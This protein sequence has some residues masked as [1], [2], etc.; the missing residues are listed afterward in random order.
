MIHHFPNFVCW[1]E[2]YKIY[3][4]N[5]DVIYLDSVSCYVLGLLLGVKGNYFSGPEMA[6][7]LT[8]NPFETPYFLLAEDIVN[9]HDSNKFVLPVKEDFT[10]EK[11]MLEFI[12]SVPFNRKLIIGISSPKQNVLAHYL[13]TIRPDLEI[14]CL[15]AAVQQTWGFKNANTRLRG[16]GLQWI[17]FLIF[18]P[19]R[20]LLKQAKTLVEILLIICS[21]ARIK[22][23]REFVANTR[24]R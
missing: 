20:T 4:A 8:K 10:H 19:K 7:I 23:F 15:G 11:G 16:T 2:I 12:K 3:D 14:Y 18:Q 6:Y 24:Q 5:R 22:F 9:I 1:K 17:E 13:F 21:P